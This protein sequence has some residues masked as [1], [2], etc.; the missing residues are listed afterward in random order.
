MRVRLERDGIPQSD[1]GDEGVLIQSSCCTFYLMGS[2][3]H[4]CSA[5]VASM[6]GAADR[7]QDLVGL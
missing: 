2:E 5:F 7:N 4:E 1:L 6:L 3:G